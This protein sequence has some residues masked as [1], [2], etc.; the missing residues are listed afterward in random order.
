MITYVTG[1]ATAPV[2][3][4]VRI[5]AHVCNDMGGWGRGFVLAIS[6]KWNEPEVEYRKL[7]KEGKLALGFVQFVNVEPTIIIANMVAQKGY[8]KNNKSLHRTSEVDTEIPLQYDQLA[9]CLE[10]VAAS[11]RMQGGSVHMPRIGCGLAGG[12]WHEVEKLLQAKFS[13]VLV[14]VYDLQTLPVPFVGL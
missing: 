10:K 11:A 14:Y 4:G 9:I 8:G 5:I 7:K 6:E 3:G 12:E 13:D 1:D 2:N